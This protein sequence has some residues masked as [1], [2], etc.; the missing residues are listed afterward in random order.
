MNWTEHIHALLALYRATHYDIALDDGTC[1]TLRIG[2]MLP[3][4]L[5]DWLGASCLATYLTACNPH[6]HP[7]PEVE[8]EKRMNT[9]RQRLRALPCRVLDGVGHL[10]GAAWREPSVFV[11]DL[12]LADIDA[13]AREFEQNAVVTAAPHEACRLRLYRADWPSVI[14]AGTDVDWVDRPMD[15]VSPA[16]CR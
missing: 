1:A 3:R 15:V 10:P 16:T 8:N 12:P 7:L 2:Q 5:L 4:A 14:E 6:S 9:L 13:L 11:A